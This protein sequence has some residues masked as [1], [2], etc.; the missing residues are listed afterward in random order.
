M[1]RKT[2]Y[3]KSYRSSPIEEYQKMKSILQALQS[4]P[5]KAS[6][7]K[8]GDKSLPHLWHFLSLILLPQLV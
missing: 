4:H 1:G 7:T 3:E 8:T 5:A 2:L 6:P